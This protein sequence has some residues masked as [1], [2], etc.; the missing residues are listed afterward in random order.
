MVTYALASSEKNTLQGKR[1]NNKLRFPLAKEIDLLYHI[2][3]IN[4]LFVY[5][6]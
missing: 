2:L 1:N 4:Y 6:I 3:L 5:F